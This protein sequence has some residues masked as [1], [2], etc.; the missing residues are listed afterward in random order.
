[1]T[2]VCGVAFAAFSAA[3]LIDEF[4]WG[5]PAEFHLSVTAAQMLALAY[6][7]ALV[8]LVVMA[9]SG[10]RAALPGLVLG[11][12][13]IGVADIMKHGPEIAAPGPWRS[14]LVSGLLALGLTVSAL[15]TAIAA[16]RTWRRATKG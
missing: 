13:L 5:A 2:L 9:A 14:G 3:H 7:I 1:L 11:G 4:V 15:L 6:M 16:F 8:G 12:L 10:S